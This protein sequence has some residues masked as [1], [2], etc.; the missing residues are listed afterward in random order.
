MPPVR[1]IS[2]RRLA[3]SGAAACTPGPNRHAEGRTGQR[4]A[5][6]DAK[7][8]TG[9]PAFLLCLKLCPVCADKEDGGPDVFPL[10]AS[11]RP[12]WARRCAF[13]ISPARLLTVLLRSL[14]L[15]IG[16]LAFFCACLIGTSWELNNK[17][18]QAC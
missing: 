8:R 1:S 12:G 9:A 15:L 10:R 13:F 11:V 16:P 18:L 7:Q 3:S 2:G 6:Q 4:C 17:H 5:C 14:G